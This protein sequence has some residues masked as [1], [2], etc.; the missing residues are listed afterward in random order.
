MKLT[1]TFILCFHF[2]GCGMQKLAVSNADKLLSYQIT[3]RLPLYTKQKDLLSKDIDDFLNREKTVAQDILPVID[4]ID[5]SAPEKLEGPYQKLEGFYIRVARDFSAL[6]ATHMAR[7]DRKQQEEMLETL[8]DENRKI[9]KKE[10]EDR[11]DDIEEN[12]IRLLGTISGPQKQIVRNY[13]DYFHARA[14][15]RLERRVKLHQ[16][17]RII[18]KEDRSTDSRKAQFE[19]VLEA[20]QKEV[21]QANKNLEI[22]KKIVPTFTKKQ[23]KHLRD[24]VANLKELLKY[25]LTVDY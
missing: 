18:F 9:L 8:D 11:I 14:R 13:E 17:L 25:Y 23:K 2:N 15:Q 6:I 5:V 19:T 3:R 1:L 16:E 10:K 20:Y 12:F 21:L 7:L 4:Q 22:L 24:H